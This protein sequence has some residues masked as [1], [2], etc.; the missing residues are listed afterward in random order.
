MSWSLLDDALLH[1]LTAL[2]AAARRP[3]PGSSRRS[4]A[5][6][7]PPPH[8][9][10]LRGAHRP[11]AARRLAAHSLTARWRMA[12]VL[13]SALFVI[14]ARVDRSLSADAAGDPPASH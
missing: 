14:G 8:P 6:R 13:A 7:H 12:T 2:G 4:S 9:L 11:G 10:R 3:S 1:G 5:A